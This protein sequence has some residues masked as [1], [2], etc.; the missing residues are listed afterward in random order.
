MIMTYYEKQ[1]S[2]MY[3][4]PTKLREDSVFSRVERFR[5]VQVGPPAPNPAPPPVHK[6]LLCMIWQSHK[7][8]AC[9]GLKGFFV[10]LYLHRLFW[11]VSTLFT[12]RGE[13]LP[14]LWICVSLGNICE[15][16]IPAFL[17]ETVIISVEWESK[18]PLWLLLL[19]N[20]NKS[21]LNFLPDMTYKKKLI[22][23]FVVYNLCETFQNK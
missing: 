17:H 19:N 16:Q 9:L 14:L 4:T 5:L 18:F 8:A 10:C 11:L 15:T 22:P 13:C 1:K 3:C 2:N 7:R 23:W 12:M 21:V 20:F 6:C